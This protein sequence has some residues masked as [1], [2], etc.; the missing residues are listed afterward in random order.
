MC[1]LLC[2]INSNGIDL[3]LTRAA[4]AGWVTKCAKK[5]PRPNFDDEEA[6][7]K[8]YFKE[9]VF[10]VL[11]KGMIEELTARLL[12]KV[13]ERMRMSILL[14]TKV[15]T[16][17]VEFVC[18]AVTEGMP[19]VDRVGNFM[20]LEDEVARWRTR[21]ATLIMLPEKKLTLV[22]VA[23]L[24]PRE[25]YPNIR[26]ALLLLLVTPVST[27]QAERTFSMLRRTKTWLRSTM[28]EA[29]LVGLCMLHAHQDIDINFD[30]VLDSFDNL[31]KRRFLLKPLMVPAP[32]VP[33]PVPAP[34]PVAGGEEGEEGGAAVRFILDEEEEEVDEED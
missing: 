28:G 20:H 7:L 19:P 5:N 18:A 11:I 3:K 4:R 22:Q 29:R 27:A 8:L 9:M 33:A 16:V 24:C 31:K 10:D 17:S 23:C 26:A 14:P 30:M 21:C 12:G 15:N 25:Q 2:A 32:A 1:V 6:V 34:V 13:A